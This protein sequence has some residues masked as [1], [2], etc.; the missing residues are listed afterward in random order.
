MEQI[1]IKNIA[2]RIGTTNLEVL[3]FLRNTNTIYHRIERNILVNKE[4][5]DRIVQNGIGLKLLPIEELNE[6]IPQ[7]K[8]SDEKIE[9]ELEEVTPNKIEEIVKEETITKKLLTNLP[10]PAILD[11]KDSKLAKKITTTELRKKQK[12][13][14]E[15]THLMRT[16]AD[17]DLIESNS[18]Y[19]HLGEY[20]T[21]HI[22]YDILEKHTGDLQSLEDKLET[23]ILAG[24][25]NEWIIKCAL[26][27]FKK[28]KQEKLRLIDNVDLET[29][30]ELAYKFRNNPEDL[31]TL[32]FAHHKIKELDNKS[33]DKYKNTKE[34]LEIYLKI[35]SKDKKHFVLKKDLEEEFI[36]ALT[37]ISESKNYVQL[38]HKLSEHFFDDIRKAA[39]RTSNNKSILETLAMMI[40]DVEEVDLIYTK[41]KLE[42]AYDAVKDMKNHLESEIEIWGIEDIGELIEKSSYNNKLF[43]EEFISN[44]KKDEDIR[45]TLVSIKDTASKNSNFDFVNYLAAGLIKA[46]KNEEANILF[47][48][49]D[50]EQNK[51]EKKIQKV[52]DNPSFADV[53]DYENKTLWREKWKEFILN[54]VEK[55]TKDAKNIENARKKFISKLEVLCLPGPQALEIKEVY[56]E[57]GIPEENITCLEM[58]YSRNKFL[59]KQVPKANVLAIGVKVED[60][61]KECDKQYDIIMLDMDGKLNLEM[62]QALQELFGK[63]VLKPKSLFATNFFTTRE[64]ETLK[65]LYRGPLRVELA[66]LLSEEEIDELS[67]IDK[68]EI[69]LNCDF[70]GIKNN[71]KQVRDH[72]ITGILIKTML[73]RQLTELNPVYRKLLRGTEYECDHAEKFMN[74]NNRFKT[75]MYNN[76]M[77]SHLEEYLKNFKLEEVIPSLELLDVNAYFIEEVKCFRYQT[78]KKSA[79]YFYSDFFELNQHEEDF[80]LIRKDLKNLGNNKKNHAYFGEGRFCENAREIIR[81]KARIFNE[82][83]SDKYDKFK[84]TNGWVPYREELRK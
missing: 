26:E 33:Q 31:G 52:H 37:E 42:S 4:L 75:L 69:E 16:R 2:K 61:V 13:E 5:G 3:E 70:N 32:M 9:Q 76:H 77:R 80:E 21:F 66:D 50:E 17:F 12:I 25:D 22:A 74:C 63:N 19:R 47:N 60:Y 83:M 54:Y 1:N 48:M 8:E 55:N 81:K 30:M 79:P 28:D 49:S 24:E 44:L 68:L 51:L 38:V 23:R 11:T 43:Q 64:N 27:Y 15:D 7:I 53:Y 59:K 39:K 84:V 40:K 29:P 34:A 62:F 45:D 58:D 18:K 6:I 71:L 35:H 73:G 57:I 10:T 82:K 14:Q 78:K 72:G 41:R 36:E 56:R 67:D 65:E 46:G 20:A